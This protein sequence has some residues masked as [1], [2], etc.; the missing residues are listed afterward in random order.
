[1][2]MMLMEGGGQ[3]A[4]GCGAGGLRRSK[5][6]IGSGLNAGVLKWVHSER[7]PLNFVFAKE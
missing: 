5:F 6:S 4:L 7:Y 2:I 1:M 3:L